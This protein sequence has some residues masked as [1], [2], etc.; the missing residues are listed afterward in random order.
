M[1]ILIVDVSYKYKPVCHC[2]SYAS[3]R[4]Y[5]HGTVILMY[6]RTKNTVIV[7]KLIRWV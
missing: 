5:G 7:P 3:G 6:S 2:W 1:A 4:K